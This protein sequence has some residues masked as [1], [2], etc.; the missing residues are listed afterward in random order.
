[1][2]LQLRLLSDLFVAAMQKL[3]RLSNLLTRKAASAAT[4]MR[5]KV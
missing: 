1:M 2:P 3:R 5:P 4:A